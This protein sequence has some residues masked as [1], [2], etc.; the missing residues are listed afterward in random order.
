MWVTDQ[1]G[2]S[3]WQD[4]PYPDAPTPGSQSG[5][6]WSPSPVLTAGPAWN[7]TT[8]EQVPG[9]TTTPPDGT[10]PTPNANVSPVSPSPGGYS[11][12]KDLPS[13]VRWWQSQHPAT[14][15][16]M[17]GLI[18][19]LNQNGLQAS[20]ALHNG[21]AS[22]DKI[23]V[24]GQ[25]YDLGS[26]L[27]SAQG[28]WFNNFEP[29]GG[30]DGAAAPAASQFYN[31]LSPFSYP[32]FAPQEFNAPTFNAPAPFSYPEFAAPSGQQVLTEDPGYGFR[33][34]EGL[35]TIR[36]EK[37]AQGILKTGGTLKS[38][39]DWA[40][41]LASQ[42]YGQAYDR[43]LGSWQANRGAKADDY[44][45][46][47]KNT[48]SDYMLKYNAEGDKFNRSLATYGANNKNAVTKY[49]FDLDLAGGKAG[50]Q[51]T[52]FNQLLSLYDISTRDLPKYTPV[53]YQPSLN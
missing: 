48:L 38:L 31:A 44:D 12:A 21:M 46:L 28:S 41:G 18:A 10:P 39:A 35:R 16:D 5:T 32:D 8:A 6:Q 42:E 33:R 23:T 49:G 25:M 45:R 53:T 3:M 9:F 30:G 4:D 14:A 52:G 37:S 27:G 26:S 17:P 29:M 43:S 22:D 13:L 7:R 1:N 34:D 47:W 51:N 50:Q 36:N 19:F 11:G 20:T 15:P 2:E 24:G 40:E